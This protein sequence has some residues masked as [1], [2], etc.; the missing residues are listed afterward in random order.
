MPEDPLALAA[1]APPAGPPW[2][3]AKFELPAA[4]AAPVP[5]VRPP[6]EC[7]W[8]SAL[9]AGPAA[10]RDA[11][12]AAPE[13]RPAAYLFPPEVPDPVD[14]LAENDLLLDAAIPDGR[15]A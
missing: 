11:D 15:P 7:H 8:P 10:P 5:P 4:R 1:R 14:L 13:F 3:H 6:K 2:A 9:A 12:A